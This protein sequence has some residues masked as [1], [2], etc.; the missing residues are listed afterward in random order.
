MPEDVLGI[1][2]TNQLLFPTRCFIVENL[3]ITSVHLKKLTYAYI[4]NY[5]ISVRNVEQK[6]STGLGVN[7]SKF[8]LV[9]GSHT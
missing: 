1:V 6:L 8:N 5:T 4:K 2:A 9:K 7:T 3:S